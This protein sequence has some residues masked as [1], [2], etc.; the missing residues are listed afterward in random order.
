MQRESASP[1]KLSLPGIQLSNT[2]WAMICLM[3]LGAILRLWALDFGLPHDSRPDELPNQT[4]VLFNM[5]TPMMM[6]GN[7]SLNPKVF[8]YGTLYYHVLLVGYFFYYWLGQL[9]G[10]FSNW[11]T[12]IFAF[13]ANPTPFHLII[14]LVS[15]IPSILMIPAMYYLGRIW[16]GERVGW[17][18]AI[19]MTTCYLMVRNAHFGTPDSLM[20]LGIILSL[21]AIL[22]YNQAYHQQDRVKIR[23][24]YLLTCLAIGLSVG[25]KYPAAVLL[26]PF[27]VCLF[28]SYL[29]ADLIDWP[30]FVEKALVTGL[31]VVG[32]FLI[33]SPWVLFDYQQFASWMSYESAFYTFDLQGIPSGWQ[34]Y[35]TFVLPHGLGILVLIFTG[36]G[37]V[38]SAGKDNTSSP[39]RWAHWILW[40]TLIAFY[41]SLGPN[42]RVMTRYAMVLVPALLLYGAYGIEKLGCLF[43]KSLPDSFS[44]QVHTRQLVAVSVF[45]LLAV[46]SPLQQSIA[47]DKLLG[48]PD[49]RTQLVNWI[50]KNVPEGQAIATGPRLG[51]VTLPL[52]Y[53]QLLLETGPNNLTPPQQLKL[54][55]IDPRTKLINTYADLKTLKQLG[56]RIMVMYGGNLLFSNPP[57]E[58]EM[59]AKQLSPIAYFMPF[60][61]NVNSNDTDLRFGIFDPMDAFFAPYV[62][63]DVYE[64]GGPEIYVF[65][66]AQLK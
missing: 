66:L 13:Q 36:L 44:V 32:I 60:K 62:Y 40:A 59:V 20:C 6:D 15:A 55:E 30:G 31:I 5:L 41:L 38:F 9:Q 18:A 4:V 29:K 10:V 39:S 42:Q 25:V 7:F 1:K 2:A 65:D 54:E 50:L 46:M 45:C 49:T 3:G 57:W 48:Q 21:I 17:L 22:N 52:S 58:F 23:R 47:F 16:Q 53:G 24:W 37:L 43:A 12:F 56:V 11:E 34:F 28:Q 27:F 8:N 64:R 26:I 33:T 35:P 51:K 19:L 61:A 14:R 63:F